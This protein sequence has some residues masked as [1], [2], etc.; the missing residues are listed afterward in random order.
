MCL[1]ML[2]ACLLVYQNK[3]LWLIKKPYYDICLT[4]FSLVVVNSQYVDHV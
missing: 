1:S 4:I 2:E 3:I